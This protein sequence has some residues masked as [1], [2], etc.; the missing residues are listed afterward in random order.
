MPADVQI[1]NEHTIRSTHIVQDVHNDIRD[2]FREPSLDG[3]TSARVDPRSYE[4]LHP[5]V[6]GFDQT[7][8]ADRPLA[9][10]ARWTRA[11]A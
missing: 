5:R 11:R 6:R 9:E 3:V 4:L 10:R 7:A 2:V 8:E 1:Q